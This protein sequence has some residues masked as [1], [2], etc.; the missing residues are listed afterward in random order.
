MRI[1]SI[2][3]GSTDSAYCIYDT[4]EDRPIQFSKLDN[5]LLAAIILTDDRF[6]R[7]VCEMISSYGMAV[8]DTI[9]ETCTWV[10]SYRQ[11][12]RDRSPGLGFEYMFRKDVKMHLC[13]NMRATDANI[14]QVLLDRFGDPGTKTNKKRPPGVLFG[15]KADEWAA[16]SVAVTWSDTHK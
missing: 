10:G 6:E 7:V 8:G 9:F 4:V 14:R 1:L 13:Q 3:P 5:S 16:L 2:D 11:A 12:C 15:M